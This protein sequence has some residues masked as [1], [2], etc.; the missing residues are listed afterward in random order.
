MADGD[1]GAP[2]D[3]LEF[4][5]ADITWP[6]I[7]HV[8]GDIYA[9]AY[10]NASGH[11]DVVTVSIA[12]NGQ[13]GAGTISD[14]EFDAVAGYRPSIV[15]VSG[16]IFAIAYR[17]VD[18]DGFVVTINITAAGVITTV[19]GGSL[20]FEAVSCHEPDMIKI[21]DGADVFAIVCRG[22]INQGI[23]TTVRI[24][25][26][27]A[28]SAIA[29]EQAWANNIEAPRII[30]VTGAIFAIVSLDGVLDGWVHTVRI[31]AAGEIQ[32]TVVDSLEY[33]PG[34][35]ADPSICH[36]AE[37][38]FAI[39]YRGAADD[40]FVV[41]INITAA[42]T[43]SLVG[44]AAG[45]LEFET[46][47]CTWPYII[48]IGGGICAIAY[49]GDLYDGFLATVQIDAAGQITA[50]QTLE[51][52]TDQ[53]FYPRII[54]VAGNICAVAYQGPG[55]DGFVSTPT[56]VIPVTARVQ[57]LLIMGIG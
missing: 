5:I 46:V 48:H 25:D 27:G 41:T 24:T 30:H 14:L 57:H 29:K 44:G 12:A 36:I 26:E 1:I 55:S 47:L 15:H 34:Q 28:I 33:E 3:T 4:D 51:I 13:I 2:Q 21:P 40:G 43:I 35:G 20:E 31:S 10:S 32:S 9:I 22:D 37:D 56:I 16:E 42:G 50:L 52:D 49:G 53:G 19:T 38:I 7:I 17:G 18:N 11:G 8:A 6:D 54:R 23:I 45:L 39:A